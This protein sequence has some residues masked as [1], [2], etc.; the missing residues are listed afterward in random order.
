MSLLKRAENSAIYAIINQSIKFP[1][2]AA[3]PGVEGANNTIAG[4]LVE[5]VVVKYSVKCF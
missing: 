3:E 2:E 5:Q 1:E 4:Q